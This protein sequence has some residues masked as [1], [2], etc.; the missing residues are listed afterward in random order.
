[1][2]LTKP[3]GRVFLV[4]VVCSMTTVACGIALRRDLSKIPQGQVGFDDMCNLQGYFDAIEAGESKEPAVASSVD[5]EG[6]DGQKTIRGGKVRLVFQ[7]DFLVSNARRV[8]EDNWQRLPESLATTDTIEF[9]VRWAE[10]AGVKRLVTNE[11]S[12][13]IIDGRPYYLPYQ[14][15]LS[16][17]LFGAPLYKQRQVMLGLPVP[18]MNKPLDL[19]LDAGP[20]DGDTPAN[21]IVATPDAA[22]PAVKPAPPAPPVP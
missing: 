2:H 20:P 11:D 14:V 18:R 4:C 12:E 21:V 5:L 15:C 8:L 17:F 22:P 6:G 3:K 7:G 10:R 13:L 16:D 9:E 1:M 19:A